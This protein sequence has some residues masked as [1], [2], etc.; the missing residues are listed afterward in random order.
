MAVEV[1]ELP[2]ASSSGTPKREATLQDCVGLLQAPSDEQKFVGLL[3]VTR[4]LDAADEE[5]VHAVFSA[6][7]Q[8]FLVRLLK[9]VRLFEK[10]LAKSAASSA[11]LDKVA[12]KAQQVL[13]SQAVGLAV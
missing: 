6:L 8:R 4:F 12:E 3:L 11:P 5:A 1:E 13:A 10:K 2:D 9:S 7:D